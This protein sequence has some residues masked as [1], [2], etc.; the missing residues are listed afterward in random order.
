MHIDT[1]VELGNATNFSPQGGGW[2]VGYGD[3]FKNP[4]LRRMAKNA[5]AHTVGLKWMVHKTGDP[6][7]TNKPISDGCT[8]SILISETGDFQLEFSTRS[9]FADTSKGIYLLHRLTKMGDFVV[10][11]GGIHHRWAVPADSTILTVRWAPIEHW[12]HRD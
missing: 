6:N 2:L 3:N 5:L 4:T 8:I 12:S 11:G 9:D 1:L 10:W 7:G